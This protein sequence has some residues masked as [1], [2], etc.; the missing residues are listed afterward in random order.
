MLKQVQ[1]QLKVGD[2]DHAPVKQLDKRTK[3]NPNSALSWHDQDLVKFE[4]RSRTRSAHL[5]KFGRGGRGG[6]GDDR[7]HARHSSSGSV[8]SWQSY[9]HLRP[10]AQSAPIPPDEDIELEFQQDLQ[11]SQSVATG[12]TRG[13]EGFKRR[14]QSAK[15]RRGFESRSALDMNW[16]K[17]V[18]RSAS[19]RTTDYSNFTESRP[20]TSLSR[21]RRGYGN[22]LKSESQVSH[23]VHFGQCNIPGEFEL[24]PSNTKVVHGPHSQVHHLLG[25]PPCPRDL[26]AKLIHKAAWYHEPNRYPK[27]AYD[28]YPPRRHQVRPGNQHYGATM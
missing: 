3:E 21:S 6:G 5:Q 16:R 12:I 14:S 1:Y 13:N 26:E 24:H 2:Y 22:Y 18:S 10:R 9:D 25:D 7:L 28:E 4:K 11:I 27:N 20:A 15:S 19:T 8:S 17:T 23:A